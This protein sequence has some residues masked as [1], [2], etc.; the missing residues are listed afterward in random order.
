MKNAAASCVRRRRRVGVAA[1]WNT[2]CCHAAAPL[3]SPQYIVSGPGPSIS[4]NVASDPVGSRMAPRHRYRHSMPQASKGADLPVP[5]PV[6]PCMNTVIAAR[7]LQPVLYS[8]GSRGVPSTGWSWREPTP[9]DTGSN[10]ALPS[11][12][13]NRSGRGG[14]PGSDRRPPSSPGHHNTRVLAGT[15]YPRTRP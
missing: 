10:C 9:N 14:T 6:S 4:S 1:P 8:P 13:S 2:C 11:S 12:T 5:V 15:L 3:A 7:A